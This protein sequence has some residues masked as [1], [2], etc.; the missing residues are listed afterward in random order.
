MVIVKRHLIMKKET[1][2]QCLLM[3]LKGDDENNRV[4]HKGVDIDKSFSIEV[5]FERRTPLL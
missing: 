5:I 2:K 1:G 3:F 4:K